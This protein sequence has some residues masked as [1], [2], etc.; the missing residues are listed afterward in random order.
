MNYFFSNFQ[1]RTLK[2][3]PIFD[4][5]RN[6]DHPAICWHF[7]IKFWAKIWT[8]FCTEFE[9]KNLF[10]FADFQCRTLKA[11]LIFSYP[12]PQGCTAET[13][14]K[15]LTFWASPEFCPEFCA[16]I[17]KWDRKRHNLTFLIVLKTTWLSFLTLSSF[18]DQ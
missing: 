1:C 4:H 6:L 7:F 5:P 14:A 2:A 16:N 3:T 8:E 18:K 15:I 12:Q 9:K 11:S 17:F 10:F 13:L